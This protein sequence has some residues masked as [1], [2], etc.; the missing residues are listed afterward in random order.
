M[1]VSED[2]RRC[3]LTESALPKAS[4]THSF[5]AERLALALPPGSCTFAGLGFD[6]IGGRRRA[7]LALAVAA[8]MVWRIGVVKLLA[9]GAMAGILASLL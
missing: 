5:A 4:S 8:Q 2:H 9:A 1:N 7:M 6:D 3:V